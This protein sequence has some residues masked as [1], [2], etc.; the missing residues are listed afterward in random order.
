MPAQ[1]QLGAVRWRALAETAAQRP[2]QNMALTR[3]SCCYLSLWILA[4]QFAGTAS[5]TVGDEAPFDYFQNS[6][7]VIGLKD[8]NDGTRVTPANELLLADK[9]L[10][11]LSCGANL[12][13]LSR[14]QTKTLLN[15]WLPVILLGTEEGGVRYDYTLWA[16]PLPSVKDWRAAFAWPTEGGNFLNW[17]RVKA[18]NLGASPAE[19]RARFELLGTNAPAP[20]I[21][22]ALLRPGRSAE[23]CFR[24]PFKPIP[25]VASFDKEQ[26]K[27]W[28]ERTIKYW[29][30]L[31]SKATQI[32]VPCEKSTQALLAAHVCQLLASDHGVLHG[33]EGFYDQFY[34]RD[35]AYQVLELE[36]AGL[37][38]AAGNTIAAYLRA[39]RPDGRF[40]TQKGQFDANG[41]ALWTLWQFYKITGDRT[42]LRHAYSQMRRAAE[43]T[44]RARREAPADSPFAGV[45][46]NALADGEYLWNGKYHIVGYDFWNL[47]GVLCVAGAARELG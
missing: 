2:D 4:T 45:L 25:G 38:E 9:V 20:T 44:A 6:W 29:R 28:L 36:E 19:A 21:W 31:M 23:T 24:I 22:T 47:R 13:P 16:T 33:G 5:A 15:G 7:N 10:L 12:T 8:Y 26:P 40:E 27:L 11:R 3:T 17:V 37:L 43:W 1:S 34:I 18:T 14:R 30:G 39:Q 46:P 42:W 41:Q 32:E 35:G